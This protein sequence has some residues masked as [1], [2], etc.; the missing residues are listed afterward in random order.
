MIGEKLFKIFLDKIGE[1]KDSVSLLDGI[2]IAIDV[3]D[4]IEIIF[5]NIVNYRSKKNKGKI[6]CLL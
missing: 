1:Y 6:N 5:E 3:F 2:K 4:K